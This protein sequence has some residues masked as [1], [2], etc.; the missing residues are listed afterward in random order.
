MFSNPH[1]QVRPVSSPLVTDK[2]LLEYSS[3]IQ[4]N[5]LGV[6]DVS[7]DH[8]ASDADKAAY[9]ALTTDAQRVA[10]L[11]QYIGLV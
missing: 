3:S 8:I 5:L 6:W 9:A 11:A 1:Q 7:H 2:Q 4:E 10:F